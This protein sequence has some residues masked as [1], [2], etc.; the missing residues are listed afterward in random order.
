MTS[1]IYLSFLVPAGVT[2][3]NVV[4]VKNELILKVMLFRFKQMKIKLNSDAV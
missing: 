2:A 1:G 4:S 3:N